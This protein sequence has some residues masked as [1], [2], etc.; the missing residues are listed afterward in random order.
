M[1]LMTDV[2]VETQ[3][4][5]AIAVPMCCKF[6]PA[7][8]VGLGYY[9]VPVAKSDS[10]SCSPY[11]GTISMSNYPFLPTY[12]QTKALVDMKLGFGPKVILPWCSTLIGMPLKGA[13]F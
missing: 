11:E 3:V 1:A 5:G 13:F 2:R 7:S 6:N 10:R 8:L 4:L 9:I 12:C